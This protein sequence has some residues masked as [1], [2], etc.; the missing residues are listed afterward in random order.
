MCIASVSVAR[1]NSNFVADRWVKELAN[2][3]VDVLNR[4]AIVQQFTLKDLPSNIG[5]I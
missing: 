5:N 4:N 1:V 3:T 2:V